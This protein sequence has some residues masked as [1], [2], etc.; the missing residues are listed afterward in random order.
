[1]TWLSAK[2][3]FK[4][5]WYFFKTYWYVPLLLSW[6]V[7]AFLIFRKSPTGI[8][9]VL[10]TAEKSFKNQIKILNGTHDKEIK[11]RD[12]IIK[13][14]QDTIAQLEEDRKRKNE[15]L[16]KKEKQ[17]IKEL[18]EKHKDNPEDFAREIAD[19]FGFE[20]VENK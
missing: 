17:R 2:I 11:E 7:I 8:L 4:K 9:D 12:Q 13:R 6:A 20:Y 18:A 3:F 19:K 15:E 16:T 5:V 14:Y 10:H 1:M